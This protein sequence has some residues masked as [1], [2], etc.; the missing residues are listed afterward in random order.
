MFVRLLAALVTFTVI[1]CGRPSTGPVLPFGD[2]PNGSQPLVI[3]E[4]LID[5]PASAIGPYGYIRIGWYHDFSQYDSLRITVSV[6]RV[7][8][9]SAYDR[10]LIKVGPAFSLRDSISAG[11]QTFSFLLKTSDL[12]KPNFAALALM[13]LDPDVMLQFS[14]LRV[15]GWG[16]R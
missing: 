12:A 10:F 5:A 15:S 8:P 3:I 4:S 13:V 11:E 16:S 7:S 2:S 1:G 6:K 9:S 14:H